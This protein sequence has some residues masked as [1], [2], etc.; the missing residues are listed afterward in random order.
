ML[1]WRTVTTVTLW[2]TTSFLA[3]LWLSM[4]ARLGADPAPPPDGALIS[5]PKLTVDGVELSVVMVDAP[6]QSKPAA[7]VP[8]NST[9]SLALVARNTMGRSFEV[10]FKVSVLATPPVSPL[11][12]VMP[13]SEEI[14]SCQR[15]IPLMP[16]QQQTIPLDFVKPLAG[17]SQISVMLSSGQQSIQPLRFSVA[18][19][20]GQDALGNRK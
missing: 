15:T 6:V 9:V 14:W 5:A 11:A 17:R 4:P 16:N 19:E 8:A 10:P 20:P 7:P 3:T 18:P 1:P 2:A 12:R 13:K